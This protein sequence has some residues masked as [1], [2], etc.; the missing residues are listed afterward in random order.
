[1]LVRGCVPAL[2]AAAETYAA[3]NDVIVGM[4]VEILSLLALP[5]HTRYGATPTSAS[6]TRL[7]CPCLTT[8]LVPADFEPLPVDH[9]PAV[10]KW[11]RFREL[12]QRVAA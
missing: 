10:G 6:R 3:T 5:T 2:V 9:L 4:A 8:W 11:V 7:P 12:L 1:M